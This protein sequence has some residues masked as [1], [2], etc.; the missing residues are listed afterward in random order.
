[1]DSLNTGASCSVCVQK[2]APKVKC[3]QEKLSL[4]FAILGE[5]QTNSQTNGEQ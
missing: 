1:M 2:N 3:M 4:R 5:K